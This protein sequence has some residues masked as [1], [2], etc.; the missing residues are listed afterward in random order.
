VPQEAVL[1]QEIQSGSWVWKL[2]DVKEP[3]AVWWYGDATTARGHC[4][5]VFIQFA[6]HGPGSAFAYGV[7]RFYSTDGHGNMHQ[8]SA[9]SALNGQQASVLVGGTRL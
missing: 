8:L 2:H 9:L 4:L 3:R 6:N 7:S 5:L 1:N